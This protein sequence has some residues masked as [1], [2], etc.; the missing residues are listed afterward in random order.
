METEYVAGIT[1]WGFI[2]GKTWTV[3]GNSGLIKDGVERPALTWLKEY[4]KNTGAARY[5][6]GIATGATK[7]LGNVI[8]DGQTI[9]EDYDTYW[10]EITTDNACTWGAVEKER[11]RKSVV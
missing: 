6:R 8:V 9:P 5:G 10:N 1:L 2:Y 4:F 11:D 3:D 7:N